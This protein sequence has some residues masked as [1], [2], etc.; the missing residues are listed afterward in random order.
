MDMMVICTVHER[1]CTDMMAVCTVHERLLYG[2]DG[3]LYCTREA[4]VRT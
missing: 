1:L 4:F 3:G 2:H